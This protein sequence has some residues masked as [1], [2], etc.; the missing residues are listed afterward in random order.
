MKIKGDKKMNWYVVNKEYVAYLL[1]FDSR[2]GFVDYGASRVKLYLGTLIE[3]PNFAYYVP[4][5]SPKQKHFSMKNDLDFHKV[6]DSGKLYAVLNLNN[7][8]PVVDKCV[9]QVKYDQIENFRNFESER[10]K[11]N[12]IKLLQIEKQIIDD[13]DVVLKQKA[14]KLHEEFFINPNSALAR[15][16]CNFPVLE[17]ACLEWQK[18][19]YS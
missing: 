8:L 18:A 9:R 7:M 16:C 15:R 19:N 12:Y 1:Q 11:T 3:L 14:I 5:S 17:R 2:V 6:I 13:M 4:I 10:E